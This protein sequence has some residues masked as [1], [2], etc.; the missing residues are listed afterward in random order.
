MT[1]STLPD[2]TEVVK[3]QIYLGD[4]KSARCPEQLSVLGITHVISICHDSVNYLSSS[5]VKHLRI[6][7]K[8]SE[9]EDL[10]IHLAEACQF[11]DHALRPSVGKRGMVFVHCMMGISRSPTVVAAYL[12][13]T[14][15]MSRPETIRYLQKFRPQVHP[16]YGFVKQLDVFA[17]C[18]YEP[19]HHHPLYRSW[20]RRHLQDATSYLNYIHDTSELVRDKVFLSTEF[21]SETIQAQSYLGDLN[22]AYV[23]SISPAAHIVS[24]VLGVHAHQVELPDDSADSMLRVLPEIF[25]YITQAMERNGPLLIHSTNEMRLYTVAC[26]FCANSL[27]SMFNLVLI[28]VIL[29]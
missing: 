2:V 20:K 14:M 5:K 15:N 21:P 29:Q 4:L 3:D 22:I 13:K 26:A 12:M 28:M 10:L 23:L 17:N 8:D 25:D 9:T 27:L 19:S 11:M 16:N 6:L 18:S 1:I 24:D 7:V